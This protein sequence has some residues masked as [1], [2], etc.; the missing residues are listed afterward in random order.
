MSNIFRIKELAKDKSILYVEDSKT[1]QKQ[2]FIF[3]NKLFKNVY[4]AYDGYEGFKKYKE[5][6][7]DIILTDLNM[8]MM[9]GL[10]MIKEIKEIDSSAK[11]IILSAHGD[12]DNLSEA[13]KLGINNF[14]SKPI[15]IEKFNSILLK[16]LESTNF[17]V[18]EDSELNFIIDILINNHQSIELLNHYK[19][20]PITND[21]IIVKRVNNLIMIKVN[22]KFAN[23]IIKDKRS[24]LISSRFSRDIL[25]Q[26]KSRKEDTLIF[27]DLKYID[28]SSKDR[29]ELRVE[30]GEDFFATGHCKG[31]KIDIEV[32]DISSSSIAF[33]IKN[34]LKSISINDN[35]DLSISCQVSMYNDYT[36]KQSEMIFIKADIFKID[37]DKVIATF[38][39]NKANNRIIDKYIK[40]RGI[41]L[42]NEYK[43][44]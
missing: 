28:K 22:Q 6:I 15:D 37:N 21:A 20:I 35:I 16:V 25:A 40:Q 2:I 13:V 11:V 33:R 41:E 5:L 34:N 3:L 26:Y 24:L 12:V 8:P 23:L 10:D 43:S 7:P 17:H 42:I 32:F 38:V 19:G 14:V 9:S 1:I 36:I 39:L 29:K 31:I 27:D 4:Q 30:P 44:I 18:D